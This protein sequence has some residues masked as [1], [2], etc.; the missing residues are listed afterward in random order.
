MEEEDM[1]KIILMIVALA[2]LCSCRFNEIKYYDFSLLD[3]S[4]P[5]VFQPRGQRY[6]DLSQGYP[7]TT[8]LPD[9]TPVEEYLQSEADPTKASSVTAISFFQQFLRWSKQS[10]IIEVAGLYQ[11]IDQN[12]DPI[13][14]SGKVVLPA[15][16]KVKRVILVSHYTI[17][18]DFEAPSNTFPLEGQLASLGYA[19]I[20]PDY[21]G[22][23]STV[24]LPHPYLMMNL[25]AQN[26]V[27]M[28]LAVKPFLEKADNGRFAPAHEEIYL[29]GY[30]QGGGTTMAVQHLLETLYTDIKIKRVFAGGGIY[31]VRY[32]FEN[33]IDTNWASYPCGVPFVVYGQIKGFGLNDSFIDK[34]LSEKLRGENNINL[35]TWFVDK[36]TSTK[37]MNETIGTHV[38]S[39]I[40][41][42]VAMD[43]TD[44][45]VSTLYSMMT[46]NSVLAYAWSPKAPVYMM[47]SID[48][49]TVPYGNA[50]RAQAR[51]PDANIQYNFGHYGTHVLCC[52]RF[53]FTVKTLLE[54]SND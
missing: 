33:F 44:Y 8:V 51:W 4:E 41:T 9:G 7:E 36:K 23:G 29:M 11:S 26:V 24:N 47:H 38:T 54:E 19:L 32:T 1:K 3:P 13:M 15:N 6:T 5:G 20:I 53:I 18:A 27:D 50:T 40:L 31:D 34:M 43:R 46:V 21:I 35:K 25:T 22:Y 16:G 42:P 28:Y 48:D 17:G 2:C 10:K 14:L 45:D 52:L 39:E 37:Q 49:D 30:S 12:G